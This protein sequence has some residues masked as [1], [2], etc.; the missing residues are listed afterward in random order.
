MSVAA[1]N[2]LLPIQI[3][4]TKPSGALPVKAAREQL[5]PG[6]E[7]LVF[8]QIGG[9]DEPFFQG[10][11]G[12]VLGDTDIVFCD[13]MS[14]DGHCQTPW[15]ACCEDPDK[16]K[17]SRASVQFVDAQRNPIEAEMKG[18]AGLKE[19]SHVLVAGVVAE[20][21]T[22]DNLIIEARGFYIE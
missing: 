21:S 3:L 2:A 8:G 20:T 6:D 10:Y 14:E 18:F 17:I 16:L 19:L 4:E 11:A 5:K 13:E 12:F 15:D 9:V 7:A 22:P 1:P